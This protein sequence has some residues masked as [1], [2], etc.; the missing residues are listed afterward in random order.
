MLLTVHSSQFTVE[1]SK[2]NLA[3]IGIGSNIGDRLGY[4]QRAVAALRDNVEIQPTLI[5]SLYE[6]EPVDYLKQDRFYNAVI[7]LETTLSPEALLAYC[8]KIEVALAKNIHIPK[9]PRTIDL[10]LLFY[11]KLISTSSDLTLPHPEVARRP[12]VLIPLAEI[13]PR[14][15]HPKEACTIE[16]LLNRFQTDQLNVVEKCLEVDWARI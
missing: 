1:H 15:V 10:D 3:Y 9:G 2:V 5:S 4:C 16:T 11:N 12:F 7:A 6:T 14:F 13:A 8:K